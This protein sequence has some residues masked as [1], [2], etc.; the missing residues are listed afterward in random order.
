MPVLSNERLQERK[1]L[2]TRAI[3]LAMAEGNAM[4]DKEERATQH[5]RSVLL[6]AVRGFKRLLYE[7]GRRELDARIQGLHELEVS[8]RK[9]QAE[10]TEA[11]AK[12][13]EAHATLR[14][15]LVKRLNQAAPVIRYPLPP[16][17]NG[18]TRD[19]L[20]YLE[21]LIR[22]GRPEAIVKF[23]GE[24]ATDPAFTALAPD[25]LEGYGD[26]AGDEYQGSY[27]G[28][29]AEYNV[30]GLWVDVLRQKATSWEKLAADQAVTLI[31]QVEDEFDR[32]KA[33]A[34]ETAFAFGSEFTGEAIRSRIQVKG[35]GD[36]DYHGVESFFDPLDD[37][38]EA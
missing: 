2:A 13:D 38:G 32:L 17:P 36:E 37:E 14:L 34:H 26:R 20:S 30:L 15:E 29:N 6:D 25:L 5:V 21:M 19:A 22:H 31:P 9:F 18:A 10:A 4:L 35:Y 27:W 23:V 7:K 24:Q 12:Y 16:K 11:L 1:E 28:V 8:P 33:D 3:N